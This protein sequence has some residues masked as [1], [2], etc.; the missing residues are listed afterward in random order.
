MK[1]LPLFAI[2]IITLSPG[3][4]SP[5]QPAGNAD[6]VAG[7]DSVADGQFC[8]RRVSGGQG[9][10]TLELNLTIRAGAVSGTMT[11][12]IYEKDARRGTIEGS[13][14]GTVISAVWKYNQEGVDDTLKLE[15]TKEQDR[16]LQ[17]PFLFNAAAGRQ[18][19]DFKTTERI[20]I[21]K[22]DCGL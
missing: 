4:G 6:T 3:C 10:D 16:L 9:K 2:A 21:P 15:F 8:F 11:D 1:L 18:Q 14:D 12:R 22:V 5:Q 7:K 17:R 19:T 13:I 20:E